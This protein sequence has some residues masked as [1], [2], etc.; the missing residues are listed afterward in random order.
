[1]NK[2]NIMEI[3]AHW[4]YDLISVIVGGTVDQIIRRAKNVMNGSM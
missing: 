4:I 3:T 2:E 1:M